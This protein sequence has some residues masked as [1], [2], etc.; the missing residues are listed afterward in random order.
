[1]N[2][3]L[4]TIII[5]TYNDADFVIHN[6]YCLEKTTKN[7]FKVIIRDNN[8]K[9]KEYLKLKKNI[10]KKTNIELIRIEDFSLR[11]SIANS[12]AINNHVSRIATSK[13]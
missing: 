4:L 2:G 3:Y 8:S 6:L 10:K 13:I 12:T 9:L 5:A 11:D 1:M 7:D